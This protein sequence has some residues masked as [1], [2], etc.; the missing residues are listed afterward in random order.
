MCV[1]TNTA[2]KY[3]ILRWSKLKKGHMI[4]TSSGWKCNFCCEI[5]CY[6]G[7]PDL[8]WK[9]SNVVQITLY[10][11]AVLVF[12]YISKFHPNTSNTRTF[13]RN[14]GYCHICQN[15]LMFLQG[16]QSKSLLILLLYVWKNL[17]SGGKTHCMRLA[18]C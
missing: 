15:C 14:L 11:S 2:E 13:I 18:G 1:K 8:M 7:H 10:Y 12:T 5:C 6:Q 9:S 17:I 3:F 16:I 4:N